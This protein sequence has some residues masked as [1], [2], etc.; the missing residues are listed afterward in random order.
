MRLIQTLSLYEDQKNK[1]LQIEESRPKRKASS[2]QNEVLPKLNISPDTPAVLLE[3]GDG[4]RISKWFNEI[5]LFEKKKSADSYDALN[6]VELIVITPSSEGSDSDK[7][8]ES[9]I[10]RNITGFSTNDISENVYIEL[11]KKGIEESNTADPGSI[12]FSVASD[13]MLSCESSTDDIN[14]DNGIKPTVKGTTDCI[15]GTNHRAVPPSPSRLNNKITSAPLN[16]INVI[17]EIQSAKLSMD[18][19]SSIICIKSFQSQLDD[20]KSTGTSIKITADDNNSNIGMKPIH[21]RSI[22]TNSSQCKSTDE[23]LANTESITK[24][25]ID[26]E[27]EDLNDKSIPIQESFMF[28]KN[29]CLDESRHISMDDSFVEVVDRNSRAE[30]QCK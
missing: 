18:D 6:G 28:D 9:V 22:G 25:P 1:L 2:V 11:P 24:Q 26:F 13:S 21:E 29:L 23:H 4:D 16:G 8:R 27:P 20:S 3:S 7:P 15:I 14:N 12:Y 10:R 30:K 17:N 5:P 19:N